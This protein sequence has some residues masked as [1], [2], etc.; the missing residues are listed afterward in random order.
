MRKVLPLPTAVGFEL[1]TSSFTMEENERISAWLKRKYDATATISV[2]M[3]NL[4][5]GEKRPYPTLWI[6]LKSMLKIL[7][8]IYPYVLPSFR[9]KIGLP[10]DKGRLGILESM[11][12]SELTGDRESCLETVSRQEEVSG[13]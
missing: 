8:R 7:P 11:M 5:N 6:G 9:Y 2:R 4:K 10:Q 3:Q 1:C 12:H 13:Q